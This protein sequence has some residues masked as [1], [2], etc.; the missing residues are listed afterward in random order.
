M[1]GIEKPAA[2]KPQA[3]ECAKAHSL[4]RIVDTR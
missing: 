1:G 3:L 2:A 4:L